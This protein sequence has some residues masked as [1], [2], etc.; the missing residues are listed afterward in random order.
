MLPHDIQTAR[1][2]LRRWRQSDASELLPILEQNL[3]HLQRWIPERVYSPA[4]VADLEERL[5]EYGAEFDAG[6]AWRFAVFS[7]DSGELMGE[8]SLFPRSAE[9]RVSIESADRVEIGYWLR[10]DAT[11]RGFASEAVRALMEV[12]AGLP[13]I[14]TVEIRCDARNEPSAA[15]PRRLGF[16]LAESLTANNDMVWTQ[17]LE[18]KC[19]RGLGDRI[20]SS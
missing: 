13:G 16:T 3:E 2:R 5:A 14:E 18:P 20:S 6:K 12:A 19:D 7:S 4:P 9:G 17:T 8:V 1:L 11:G 15:V 10:F